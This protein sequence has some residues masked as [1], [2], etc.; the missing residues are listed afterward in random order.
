MKPQ[1][2]RQKILV[3]DDHEAVLNGTVAAI[4]QQY[5]DAEIITA[6]NAQ[7]AQHQVGSYPLDLVIMDLSMPKKQAKRRAPKLE[8][9]C[10][11]N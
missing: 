6:Q 8:F 5:P 9:N 10:C 2:D 7:T 1:I 3:V 11:E 4:R